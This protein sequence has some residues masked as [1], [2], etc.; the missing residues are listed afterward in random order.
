MVVQSFENELLTNGCTCAM[1]IIIYKFCHQCT[2]RT[3]N[4]QLDP[5]VQWINV[6]SNST[7]NVQHSNMVLTL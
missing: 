5:V 3:T 2:T 6:T 1:E 7:I 4:V